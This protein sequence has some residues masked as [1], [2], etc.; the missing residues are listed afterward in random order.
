MTPCPRCV[1][2][3]I[4]VVSSEHGLYFRRCLGCWHPAQ[5]REAVRLGL[6]E[7]DAIRQQSREAQRYEPSRAQRNGTLVDLT[8]ILVMCILGVGGEK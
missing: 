2:G 4:E 1:E 5:I 7:S 8:P 3:W 6:S